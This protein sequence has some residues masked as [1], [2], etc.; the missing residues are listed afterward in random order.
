MLEWNN[1]Y[2]IN[3]ELDIIFNERYSNDLDYYKKNCIGLIVEISELANATRCFKYWSV[4]KPNKEEVLEEYAD[5][6]MMILSFFTYY[7]LKLDENISN[8]NITNIFEMF[9]KIFEQA[10]QMMY[11]GN[12]A[13]IKEIFYDMLHLGKMLELKDFE[14]YNI[15]YKKMNIVKERLDSN[16]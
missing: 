5:C 13:L 14:I 6:I 8:I 9:N 10:S 4:K 12:E 2:K 15:C 11:N 1:I 16:Y 3:K 7:D